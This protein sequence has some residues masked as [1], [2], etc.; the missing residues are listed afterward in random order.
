MGN[1]KRNVPIGMIAGVLFAVLAVEQLIGT[2]LAQL[3]LQFDEV[4][5]L[6]MVQL[7]SS[8]G[9]G[10]IAVGLLFQRRSWLPA[11]GYAVLAAIAT[12]LLP[13][14]KQNI[15]LDVG[16]I[17]GFIMAAWIALQFK[18]GKE[19]KI[20]WIVPTICVGC[21]VLFF[22]AVPQILMLCNFKVFPNQGAFIRGTMLY[23]EMYLCGTDKSGLWR[24]Q[25]VP[26]N[27]FLAGGVIFSTLWMS[28]P[29]KLADTVRQVAKPSVAVDIPE[30]LKKYK[31][32]LDAGAITQEEFDA[33]K[34]QLLGL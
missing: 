3:H 26:R 27:C 16:I 17:I 2:M 30:E 10:M 12:F 34:E 20:I 22:E 1:V 32:L 28:K 15:F 7:L 4:S 8:V 19:Q 13:I 24:I 9:Y 25:E 6:F 5:W 14:Y 21:V 23:L 31:K 18:R 11:I 33:K 29:G